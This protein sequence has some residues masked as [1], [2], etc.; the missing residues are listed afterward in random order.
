MWTVIIAGIFALIG[1]FVG[2]FMHRKTQHQNWLFRKRAEI[3]AD[4][5]RT[6]EECRKETNKIMSDDKVEGVEELFQLE[7]IYRPALSHA[8]ITRLFLKDES[9]EKFWHATCKLYA[10]DTTR[11][12]S[13]SSPNDIT[14]CLKEIQDILEDNLKDLKW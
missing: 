12:S 11:S 13:P 3:F 4:F 14:T 5:L 2:A 7:K 9:K 8:R 6:I 10:I 1:G